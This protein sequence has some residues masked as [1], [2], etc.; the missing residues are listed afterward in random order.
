MPGSVCLSSVILLSGV[1]RLTQCQQPQKA[2]L[3][4]CLKV[5]CSFSLVVVCLTGNVREWMEH[6]KRSSACSRLLADMVQSVPPGDCHRGAAMWPCLVRSARRRRAAAQP[7][8]PPRPV[9]HAPPQVVPRA[10]MRQATTV[11]HSPP[12]L[13]VWLIVW[14]CPRAAAHI[15]LPARIL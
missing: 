4:C 3:L 5:S 12:C 10:R 6:H 1:A 15:G 14:G 9:G 2:A 7:P 11:T 8:R 13:D